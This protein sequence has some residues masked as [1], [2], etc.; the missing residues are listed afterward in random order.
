MIS[1]CS[2]VLALYG[3]ACCY[4]KQFQSYFTF[5]NR[6]YYFVLAEGV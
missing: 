4:S 2:I 6:N 1:V 5:S 3:V